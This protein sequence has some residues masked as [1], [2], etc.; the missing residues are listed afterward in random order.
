MWAH[1]ESFGEIADSLGLGSAREAEKL[2]R[3]VI[4]RLRRK[5]RDEAS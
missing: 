5:Y 2:V 1:G 3:A 4:E